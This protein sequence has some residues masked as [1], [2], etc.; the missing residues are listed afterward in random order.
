MAEVTDS[1]KFR[2]EKEP[3]W[4]PT[5]MRNF[6]GSISITHNSLPLTSTFYSKTLSRFSSSFLPKEG[7]LCRKLS[8]S[9]RSTCVPRIL[10]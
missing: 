3:K 10:P 7:G 2:N 6:F 1:R 8:E 9:R 5:R 4:V